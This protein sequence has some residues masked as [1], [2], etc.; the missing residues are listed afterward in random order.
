VSVSFRHNRSFEL[1]VLGR[2]GGVPPVD[3][4]GMPGRLPAGARIGHPAKAMP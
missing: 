2:G 4:G 1:A 3:A